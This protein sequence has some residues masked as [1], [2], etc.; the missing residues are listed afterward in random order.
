M[1]DASQSVYRSCGH[2]LASD[3][4]GVVLR[5]ACVQAGAEEKRRMACQSSWVMQGF[6]GA[7]ST[8]TP[9]IV[10]GEL[11]KGLVAPR[12]T[13]PCFTTSFPAQHIATTGPEDMYL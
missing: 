6:E 4:D 7:Q 12:R 2:S 9:R 11:A 1:S 8:L 13:R 5:S 3:V 10:P